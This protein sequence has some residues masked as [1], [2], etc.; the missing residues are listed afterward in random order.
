MDIE[1]RIYSN[2]ERKQETKNLGKPYSNNK[3][4]QKTKITR[5]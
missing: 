4:Y 5:L 3:T 2:G 1:L